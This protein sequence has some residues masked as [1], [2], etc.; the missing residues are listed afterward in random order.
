ML[1]TMNVSDKFMLVIKTL[2]PTQ[3]IYFFWI[4]F[5]WQQPI[6]KA[7]R[8]VYGRHEH[9]GL[10]NYVGKVLILPGI[11][12]SP[13]FFWSQ[14]EY[15]GKIL[16]S[17]S[18]VFALQHTRSTEHFLFLFWAQNTFPTDYFTPP[19]QTLQQKALRDS[20]FLFF[21][22]KI[23]VNIYLFVSRHAIQ[24]AKSLLETSR[25]EI[26]PLFY[27][28]SFSLVNLVWLTKTS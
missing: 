16:Q 12:F 27:D 22:K 4:F 28:Y 3:I 8:Q 9:G 7:T 20:V 6:Q 19:L 17:T 1:T 21:L 26:W 10:P 13:C 5:Q 18:S 11:L 23:F 24:K 14:N 25:L 2:K 15:F